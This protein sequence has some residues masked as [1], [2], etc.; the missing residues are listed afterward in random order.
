M[1]KPRKNQG[2]VLLLVLAVLVIASVVLSGWAYRNSSGVL[3]A[4][5]VAQDIHRK[6]GNLSCQKLMFSFATDFL[7]EE[8]TDPDK[9]AVTVVREVELS[10]MRYQLTLS[11][12]QAKAN[13]NYLLREKGKQY[14]VRQIGRLISDKKN[15]LIVGLKMEDGKIKISSFDQIFNYKDPGQL[16]GI[17]GLTCWGSEKINYKRGNKKALQAMTRGILS[18]TDIERLLDFR[19]EDL[20][21]E[22]LREESVEDGLKILFKKLTLRDEQIEPLKRIFTDISSCKSLWVKCK[23]DTRSWYRLYVEIKDPE[24]ASPRILVY[25]W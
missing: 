5:Q 15:K 13:V 10:G 1:V 14:A 12:E 18:D 17:E 16:V 3:H 24:T 8:S 23:S 4:G 11:D 7:D 2:F 9:P 6:W 21:N 19:K 25:Q 22:D 20:G